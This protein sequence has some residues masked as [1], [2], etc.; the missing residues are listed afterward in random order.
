MKLCR[1]FVHASDNSNKNNPE[2]AGDNF[3]KLDL[4]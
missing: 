4:C 1:D 3:S 2:N